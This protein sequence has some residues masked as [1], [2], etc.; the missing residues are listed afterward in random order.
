MWEQSRHLCDLHADVLDALSEIYI[1]RAR[2]VGDTVPASINELL[3]LRGLLPKESGQKRRGGYTEKQRAA[4]R[5]ALGQIENIWMIF[6]DRRD[7]SS[8]ER[9]ICSEMVFFG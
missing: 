4:I 1:R 2:R 6:R 9:A 8:N 7:K 5:E 3:S